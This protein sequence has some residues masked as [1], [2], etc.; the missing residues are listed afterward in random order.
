[1]AW[2]TNYKKWNEFVKLDL[3]LS[4]QL[5]EMESDEK[6]IEDCF[7]KH[8]EFGT[9]G[10]RGELGP[11]TNRMNIYTIRKTAEGLARYIEENGEEAKSRGVVIAYD[12][13]HMSPEFALETA[14]TLG[15]HGIQ[16]YVF[17]SLRATPQLSF[18]VRYLHAYSGVVITASHN[19][20][21]YNGFKVYGPDGAQ[22]SSDAADKIIEKVNEVKDE[23]S[24]AVA[25]E[26]DLKKEGLLVSIGEIVDRA[27]L[28]QL[29]TI[30]VN[31]QVI[32]DVADDFRIVYTPLHGTGN[33]PVR[34]GLES[35]GFKNI[36]VVKEQEM[37]DPNFSTVHSPN[38]EE[39]AA[40]EL[41]IQYGEK[42][43]AD[44]LL[45][46]DP[47]ADRVGVAVRNNN[48][49]YQVLTGN[50]VGALLL[51]YLIQEKKKQGTLHSNATVLKTIVTSEMG[52]DIASANGL[53]T[54][55]TLTGFKYI[56]E[57]IKNFE[58]TG[59]RRFLFGYEES[60][61]YLIGD[62]VR[63]K[64]AIQT[65]LLIAEVAAY[66]KSNDKTLYEGLIELYET[67][68]YYRENLVSLTLKGKDGVEQIGSILNNFR[69][70]PPV[71]IAG[72]KVQL[73]EDYLSG[74]RTYSVTTDTEDITLPKSNVIKYKLD[75]GAWV[76]LRP[77]GTEPKI[78]F[79][80]GVKEDSL[81]ESEKALEE[82]ERDVISR[83]EQI[84]GK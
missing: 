14:K 37:P 83:V 74:V 62:F 11:G 32:Q 1:M 22:L 6:Q 76:C 38:P 4:N 3:E 55:D 45:G 68:G 63:D 43:N 75:D 73:I 19:P 77:S 66:Y 72:K 44:I 7:Y 9:G 51:H 70:N 57:W 67:Y 53:D 27:Y 54:I 26:E 78:K 39:H 36:E 33:I 82:L 49:E 21:E 35:I 20:K 58:E 16:T 28:Q 15:A 59:D 60:Y 48:G 79:Y 10:M 12:S 18:S 61:G 47:D 29:Q 42:S 69:D 17:E 8:L 5:N 34:K 80:F 24:V 56:S 31:P 65:C 2:Q 40:F 23:L 64:D 50:Q 41:A 25:N 81:L 52:R 71:E 46:T 84:V 13:R 30:I